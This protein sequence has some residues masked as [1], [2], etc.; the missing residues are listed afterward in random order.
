MCC[1]FCGDFTKA[2]A[3]RVAGNTGAPAQVD[4]VGL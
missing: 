2:A 4:A 1:G 3:H